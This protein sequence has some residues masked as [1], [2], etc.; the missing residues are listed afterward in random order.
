MRTIVCVVWL[1][2][3]A[4]CGGPAGPSESDAALLD[5]GRDAAADAG[6]PCAAHVSCGECSADARCGWCAIGPGCMRGS[7]A[8]PLDSS[9]HGPD[10][11]WTSGGVGGCGG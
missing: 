8:G 3:A 5:G 10:G 2:V 1:T 7:S 11:T 9:C 6:D 4:S